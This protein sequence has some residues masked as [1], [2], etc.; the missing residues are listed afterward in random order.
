MVIF[1][2]RPTPQYFR[3][4][5]K[6]RRHQVADRHDHVCFEA[7]QFGDD[8]AKLFEPSVGRPAL[9]L[10][11]DHLIGIRKFNQASPPTGLH[12][13][14]TD[15]VWPFGEVRVWPLSTA[16]QA[17]VGRCAPT[18]NITRIQIPVNIRAPSPF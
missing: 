17:A 3:T 4:T 11:P 13:L 2:P 6:T 18:R 12:R 8:V 9:Q 7:D 1:F 10:P 5:R 16:R 14:A 15:R